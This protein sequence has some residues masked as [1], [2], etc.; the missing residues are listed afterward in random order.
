MYMGHMIRA[1]V[2]EKRVKE[3][4]DWLKSGE[5]IERVLMMIDF[6]MKFEPERHRETQLQYY[7]KAGMSWHGAGIFYKPEKGTDSCYK[8]RMRVLEGRRKRHRN[9]TESQKNARTEH[10]KKVEESLSV[11]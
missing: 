8:E 10:T 9:E 11:F 1:E 3:L 7:G 6:K 4:F 2:Q 5:T